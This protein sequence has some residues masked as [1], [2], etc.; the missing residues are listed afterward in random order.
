MATKSYLHLTYQQGFPVGIRRN[1]PGN[2]RG[3]RGIYLGETVKPGGDTATGQTYYAFENMGY[4]MRAMIQLLLSRITKGGYDTIAKL[5][6]V[7]PAKS[8]AAEWVAAVAKNAG[9]KSTAKLG[10][11]KA[12]IKK[13]ALGIVRKEVGSPW[14]KNGTVATIDEQDFEEGWALLQPAPMIA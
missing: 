1:N 14:R 8:A 11:D 10:T 4:G 9:I 12:T 7:Y 6:K 3:K 2:L 5:G 13:L